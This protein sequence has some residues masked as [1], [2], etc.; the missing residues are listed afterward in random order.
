MCLTSEKIFALL[1]EMQSEQASAHTVSFPLRFTTSL[2]GAA[3]FATGLATRVPSQ[4]V[5]REILEMNGTFPGL[6]LGSLLLLAMYAAPAC[7]T[8]ETGRA[9][10]AVVRSFAEGGLCFA[11]GATTLALVN[12][13]RETP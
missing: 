10:V 4:S 5:P 12:G 1:V 6:T 11:V 2:L 3:V 7:V 8:R 9:V 13:K